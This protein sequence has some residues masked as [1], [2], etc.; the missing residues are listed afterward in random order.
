MVALVQ[1][2]H[3]LQYASPELWAD[4]DVVMAASVANDRY[5]LQYAQ[6]VA[7]MHAFLRKIKERPLRTRPATRCIQGE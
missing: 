3:A 4:R 2:G 7:P 1:D 5:A 6:I